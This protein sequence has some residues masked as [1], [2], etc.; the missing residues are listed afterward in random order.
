MA[1]PDL[2]KQALRKSQ[3]APDCYD[4]TGSNDGERRPGVEWLLR[5]LAF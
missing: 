4:G 2:S 1:Q 5:R 3:P